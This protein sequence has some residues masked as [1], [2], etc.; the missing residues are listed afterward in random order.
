MSDE[1]KSAAIAELRREVGFGCPVCRSPFLTWHHFDPPVHE[2]GMH[3]RPEGIIAMCPVCHADADEKGDTAG[4]YS[5]SELRAMKESHRSTDD[6]KGHFPAWEDKKSLLVRMGGCYADIHS[7]LFSINEVPQIVVGKND[8]G[9]LTLS[10]ELRDRQDGILLRMDEN[11]LTAYPANIHDMTV[12]PK[13]KE[14]KV[15]LDKEDVGLQL[16]FRRITV[17]ELD[18]MLGRDRERAERI[19]SRLMQERLA[20]LPAEHRAFLEEAMREARSQPQ[21]A[22]WGLDDLP[23]DLR[24]A[25]LSKDQVGT[26][27]KRWAE[28]HCVMD[29]GLIPL[30]DFEQ[31]AI[32][33]HGERLM[34]KNGVAGFLYYNA[35][36]GC[37][38]GAIN[39]RCPCAT[40][41]PKASG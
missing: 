32:Y 36:F 3:W 35:A 4:A 34:I 13:T 26:F 33:H 9:I 18:R 20:Q 14:V 28:C 30:L 24:E 11:C 25:V 17:T 5:K 15:W 12:T 31:M 39:V 10:F 41:S 27:V 37:Q 38:K 6:V 40:C 23:E 21:Q 16:S 29:D 22:I 19:A 2:K 7:P 1:N 8:A